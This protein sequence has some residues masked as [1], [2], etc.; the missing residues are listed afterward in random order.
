MDLTLSTAGAGLVP[1]VQLSKRQKAA[2]LVRLLRTEGMD[3]S[4]TA[5]PDDMQVDLTLEMGKLRFISRETLK[6]VID[7]FVAELDAIGLSF[8]GGV[9]GALSVLDGALSPAAM[10]TLRTQAGKEAVT[11]AWVRLNEVDVDKLA[12]AIAEESIEVGAVALSKLKVGKAAEILGKLPGEKARRLAYVMGQTGSISP[13]TVA[14]IGQALIEQFDAEPPKAFSGGPVER[15]GA[16]LNF[17]QA[18]TRE[19]VLDA[20]DQED[21]GFADE[22]RKAIFTFANIADRIDARD[23]PKV[24]REIEGGVLTMALQAATANERDAKVT[25][26]VLGNMSK[27]MAEQL[28]EDM[29]AL[30]KVKPKDGEA[31]MSQIVTVIRDMEAKGDLMLIAE[32]EDE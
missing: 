18:S 3:L 9:S 14:R 4:L 30:G 8:T 25:E 2:I 20:L 7:E 26:F 19:E 15:V 12:A 5:M 27:R 23:I 1:A 24:I 31:A 28:R 32:D 22:V 11:D 29:A 13:I 17:S 21:K 6:S 10:E 16:I